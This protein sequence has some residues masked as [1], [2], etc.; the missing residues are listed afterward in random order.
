HRLQA[1]LQGHGGWVVGLAFSPDGKTLASSSNDATVKLWNLTVQQ[2][3][4][5]LPGAP[6]TRLL[7]SPDGNTLAAAGSDG[8]VRLWRAAPF[9]QT[10][11]PSG[12][13]GQ[14]TRP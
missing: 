9:A 14:V 1:V 6:F 7:F 3:V 13:A 4:A 10:D 2:E 12:G 5:T 8:I 11:A